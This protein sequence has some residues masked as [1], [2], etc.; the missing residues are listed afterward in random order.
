MIYHHTSLGHLPYILMTGEMVPTGAR[1]RW[2]K[3]FIWATTDARGDKAV[4]ICNSQARTT[5]PHVRIGF[6]AG[7][8]SPWKDLAIQEGWM[9]DIIDD[10]VMA[11]RRLGQ[12]DTTG[13][14]A[15]AD[16]VSVAEI[17][18]IEMKTWTRPWEA[19]RVDALLPVED[20]GYEFVT[21][22]KRWRTAR[23]RHANGMLMYFCKEIPHVEH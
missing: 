21:C 10:L 6:D 20:D 2:P 9:L 13:W 5:I 23:G 4:S 17:K 18:T 15:R 22:R 1:K 3:D 12:L 7:A 8:W 11:A 19:A 14:M 16:A